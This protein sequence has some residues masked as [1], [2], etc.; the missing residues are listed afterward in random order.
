M[1][2]KIRLVVA[3][4]SL[5]RTIYCRRHLSSYLFFLCINI[6]TLS[7][8]FVSHTQKVGGGGIVLIIPN[9]RQQHP[10]LFSLQQMLCILIAFLF[11][12]TLLHLICRHLALFASLLLFGNHF[13]FFCYCKLLFWLLD[14]VFSASHAL[15]RH[16]CWFF[17][18]FGCRRAIV[19][20]IL[21]SKTTTNHE[22]NFVTFDTI[23]CERTSSKVGFCRPEN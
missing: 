19:C 8:S 11:N 16:F 7:L 23:V 22:S 3:R 13:F 2:I 18:L 21:N 9:V 4:L 17:S 1:R 12:F 6:S 14:V 10:P 15:C 20:V 5:Y